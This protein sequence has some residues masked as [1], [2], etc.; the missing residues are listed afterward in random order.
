MV[1][2]SALLLTLTLGI[3]PAFAGDEIFNNND[4]N[5]ILS[6][7][8]DV[9]VVDT[10]KKTSEYSNCAKDYTFQAGADD[11]T[12]SAGL[13]KAQECFLKEINQNND[14]KKLEE[15]SNKLGLQQYGLVQSNS[16]KEIQ[17]YLNDK[18]YQALTGIDRKEQDQKKQIEAMK[19][20]NMKQVDQ[21]VFIQ[22]YKNQLGKNALAEISRFCFEKL[23]LKNN[24]ERQFDKHWASYTGDAV[25]DPKTVDDLGDPPFTT[26]SN[27]NDAG[28]VY[29][30]IFASIQ[31]QNFNEKK[32][33]NFFLHCGKLITP[34]CDD[35]KKT[36]D[37]ASTLSVTEGTM[38]PGAAACLTQSRIQD[39]K[40]AIA[41]ADL[42]IKDFQSLSEDQKTGVFLALDGKPK[43]YGADKNDK[44]ID[45]LTNLSS[46]DILLKSGSDDER[47]KLE[48]ACI[49]GDKE[50]CG[51]FASTGDSLDKAKHNIELQMTLKR[52]VEKKRVALLKG[53][54]DDSLEEYLKANGFMELL[55]NDKYKRMDAA[56]LQT[57]I[58]KSFEA[59]K[60]SLILE[61]NNKLGS[62]QVKKGE[63]VE[64]KAKALFN[65]NEL[66]E[67]KARMTQVVL[68]HN[69][70]SSFLT[71]K[72]EDDPNAQGR[73]V[74]T[75]NKEEEG[76]KAASVDS[77]YFENIKA[78][79]EKADKIDSKNSGMNFDIL[80]QFLK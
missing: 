22:L 32:L 57:E 66:K 11:A 29:Q 62:R 33:S 67:E 4:K 54:N 9:E 30:E 10:L 36:Q 38:T 21:S 20:K 71:L 65:N 48:Q 59:R 46:A 69:I 53:K 61:I 73:N 31:G 17:S 23:R 63:D 14:P 25:I 40:K 16:S 2:K 26:F 77:S 15:L 43:M 55:E 52:E 37:A 64:V 7:I 45:E 19:F 3:H 76:L 44:G 35:Y 18:L 72:R 1:R 75:W 27:P 47:E 74:E 68:F 41:A 78:S 13:K 39:F 50:A 79:N 70:I 56:E 5:Q 42:V 8:K 6:S 80:D 28:T 49:N 34:L 58:G 24:K 51:S 60:N 12:R